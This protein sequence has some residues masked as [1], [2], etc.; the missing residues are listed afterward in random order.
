MPSHTLEAVGVFDAREGIANKGKD[1]AALIL[2][3]DCES[4]GTTP[5]PPPGAG[6]LV[7]KSH[8][9]MGLEPLPRAKFVILLSVIVKFVQTKGLQKTKATEW[10]PWLSFKVQAYLRIAILVG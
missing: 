7:R 3:P 8:R 1:H 5:T 10:F 2:W 6:G 9:V 4:N